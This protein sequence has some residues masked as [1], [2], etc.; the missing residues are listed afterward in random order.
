[1]VSVPT[2][3]HHRLVPDKFD[4]I[5]PDLVQMPVTANAPPFLI[6]RSRSTSSKFKGTPAPSTGKVLSRGVAGSVGGKDP[7][8]TPTPRCKTTQATQATL[9]ETQHQ[10]SSQVPR[11]RADARVL[12]RRPIP[13]FLPASSE[14][15]D[16]RSTVRPGNAPVKVVSVRDHRASASENRPAAV[17]EQGPTAHITYSTSQSSL[18]RQGHIPDAH[19]VEGSLDGN[20]SV[21]LRR[22]LPSLNH[23]TSPL[24]STFPGQNAQHELRNTTAH[25]GLRARNLRNALG[26]T[27]RTPSHLDSNETSQSQRLG[28][29]VSQP[30][31]NH[32]SSFSST[33]LS[34]SF[35]TQAIASDSQYNLSTSSPNISCPLIETELSGPHISS[36]APSDQYSFTLLPYSTAK[37]PKFVPLERNQTSTFSHSQSLPAASTAVS[38]TG[39]LAKPKL[40]LNPEPM[41]SDVSTRRLG[42]RHSILNVQ[43]R[44]ARN[45]PLAQMQSKNKETHS[46]AR[47]SGGRESSSHEPPSE[48]RPPPN[49]PDARL[50]PA[51]DTARVPRTRSSLPRPRSQMAESLRL[52]GHRS[53]LDDRSLQLVSFYKHRKSLAEAQHVPHVSA[54]RFDSRM[55]NKLRFNSTQFSN[56]SINVP[57]ELGPIDSVSQLGDLLESASEEPEHP[58]K[59]LLDNNDSAEASSSFSISSSLNDTHLPDLPPLPSIYSS[60]ALTNN[61]DDDDV[62]ERIHRVSVPRRVSTEKKL[63]VVELDY[64]VARLRQAVEIEK[65]ELIT[66]GYRNT[67]ASGAA[68]LRRSWSEKIKAQGGFDLVAQKVLSAAEYQQLVDGLSHVFLQ[69]VFLPSCTTDSPSLF[70][71]S[72]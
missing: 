1:M 29:S 26:I 57:S 61:A 12:K 17:S 48:A 24:P 8:S 28:P 58:D 71:T 6:V 39:S 49:M 13:S 67:N 65:S 36:V 38:E 54:S 30:S 31:N 70:H 62:N 10:R 41:N 44:G 66:R 50:P 43:G 20:P 22:V 32:I 55:Y 9:S 37:Q 33:V 23:P 5:L 69:H 2:P 42:H 60:P 34:P 68:S 40:G 3:D 59:L 53:A 25:Q 45:Q 47:G 63:D 72:T 7:P 21:E 35:S 51:E 14:D 18:P 46:V 19:S 11:I 64:D 56:A 15:G 4:T 16:Y 52:P 27:K